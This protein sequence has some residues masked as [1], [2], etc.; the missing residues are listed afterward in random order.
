MRINIIGDGS[1]GQRHARILGSLGH[2]C[3][4]L[5]PDQA[6]P[7]QHPAAEAVVIASPPETHK[8][9]LSWFWGKCPILCEGPVTWVGDQRFIERTFYA[10][11]FP[12]PDGPVNFKEPLP[13]GLCHMVASNWRFT[14]QMQGLKKKLEGKDPVIAHFW[15]DYDLAKWR[16]DVDYR[17]TCYYTTGIDYINLHSVDLA[18]YLFGP[19]KE[20]HVVKQHTGKSLG[21][22]ALGMVIHHASGTISTVN[23][24]WHAANF[25]FGLR[26]VTAD[27]TAEEVGWSSPQDDSICNVS[28]EEMVKHWLAAIEKNDCQVSPSLL[29]GFRAFK[30]LQGEVV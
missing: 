30:A 18:F 4:I 14:P 21:V 5:G 20:V 25:Q 1:A 7:V 24:S 12:G 11:K 29:D 23:S 19:A 8:L 6:S 2:V 16:P 17:T 22:D 28:Y 3:T 15:F 13:P 9:Y 27:G 26:L 10:H